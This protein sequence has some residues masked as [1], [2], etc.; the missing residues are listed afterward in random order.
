MIERQT[1]TDQKP[2]QSND[3]MYHLPHE[4]EYSAE[5]DVDTTLH[6]LGKAAI[7]PMITGIP[8]HLNF[9]SE[10]T[11]TTPEADPKASDGEYHGGDLDRIAARSGVDIEEIHQAAADSIRRQRE[12]GE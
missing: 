3:S 12:A 7:T 6:E 8:E 4:R 9:I 1:Q 5:H 11:V 10:R 2:E